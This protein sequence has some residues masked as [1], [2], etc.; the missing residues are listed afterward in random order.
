MEDEKRFYDDLVN[1][2]R[3]SSKRFSR[4]L[5][6]RYDY[7]DFF[8]EGL[9]ILSLCLHK[10]RT[11]K[12]DP[13]LKDGAGFFKYCKTALFNRFRQIQI[14]S[15]SRKKRGVHVSL[16]STLL[17][18]YDDSNERVPITRDDRA[19]L[20]CD[21]GFGE[22]NY[23]EL[24]DYVSTFLSQEEERMFRLMADPPEDL[25]MD[26][27][28]ESFRKHKSSVIHDSYDCKRTRISCRCL[29]SYFNRKYGVIS[30]NHFFNILKSVRETAKKAVQN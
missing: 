17:G 26:A 10:W 16:E 11:E 6:G 24:V 3:W 1:L 5:V 12:G 14:L 15:H 8:E 4:G 28:H 2:I 19:C 20:S 22:V 13:E 7:W 30:D 18:F 9:V 29:H 25:I 23:K 27:L 21:G